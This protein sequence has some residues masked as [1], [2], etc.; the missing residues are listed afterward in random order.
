MEAM[1]SSLFEKNN[2]PTHSSK[3]LFH[4]QKLR[5]K[6]RIISISGDM[7]AK[8]FYSFAFSSP[9]KGNCFFVFSIAAQVK[10]PMPFTA[11]ILPAST[12]L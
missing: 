8:R 11:T 7:I 10:A 2:R 6:L 12:I 4:H 3:S 5:K 1:I 9:Q